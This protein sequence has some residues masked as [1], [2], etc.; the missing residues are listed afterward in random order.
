M[1]LR[2]A[3]FRIAVVISAGVAAACAAGATPRVEPSRRDVL[4]KR[5]DEI[6]NRALQDGAYPGIAISISQNGQVLY[7]KGAGVEDLATAEAVSAQTVFP[8][9]SITKSFTS[10]A[11]AQLAADGAIDLDASIA[12]YIDDLPGGW[13]KIKV[14]HLMN[15]TAGAF[16]YTDEAAI[17]ADPG[18]HYDFDELRAI[19]E[20]RP[21]AF[22]PGAG[23]RYS[24]SGY[25]LLGKIIERASGLTYA[26]YLQANVFTPFDMADTS[27]PTGKEGKPGAK[28]YLLGD[29]EQKPS[30]AWSPSIPYSAGAL[31]STVGDLSKYAEMVHRSE[32]V[33]DDERDILYTR[34]SVSGVKIPYALG[35][36]NVQDVEGRMRYSHP[37]SI[38]GYT[39][40]FSYYPEEGVAI[41]ILTNGDDSPV[42]PSNMERK[43]ARATFGDPQP[44]YSD[45]ALGA[46]MRDAIVGDYSI[47]PMHF[48]SSTIGFADKNGTVFLF[49]GGVDNEIAAFPLRYVGGD[50]FVAHHDDELTVR[51]CDITDKAAGVEIMILGGMLTGRR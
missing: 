27:F 9:G 41:S 22:E 3:L 43:L 13:A 31:L 30:P 32:K 4:E 29:G 35:G 20:N 11:V 39:S 25:Y 1:A 8:I 23:W 45:V 42:H 10:L 26:Q 14:R 34:D 2:H 19:W 47:A 38:W 17:Q 16:D 33:T 5:A 37:G 15:H 28:G 50:L 48:V 21:L 44:Q 36:L 40:Y 12:D 7:A 49:F 18:K 51:F 24:N 6:L 46:E